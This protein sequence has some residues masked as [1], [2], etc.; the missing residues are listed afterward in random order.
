MNKYRFK[1]TIARIGLTTLA[2]VA[3]LAGPLF[4]WGESNPRALAMGG[5]YTAL[6]FGHEAAGYNPANLGLSRTNS[7]TIDLFS[8]GVS[9][10]NNS[11]SLADYNKYTGAFLTD[12]DKDAI[13]DKIPSEGLKL[14]VLT[15]AAGLNFAVGRLAFNFRGLGASKINLDR[16]PF[17]LLLYGNAVKSDVSLSDTRGE[18]W[19][20]A[21]GA[22]SYGHS[23][24]QWPGGELAIG[25]SFHY[26]YGI[27]HEK[28]T[29]A[30]GGVSTTPGGFIGDGRMIVRS[31][32][33]GSGLAL[34]LG[35][36][37][38][39]AD[40]WVFSASWQNVYSRIK[41]DRDNEEML[42]TFHM[43]PIN[44]DNLADDEIS[45]SLVTSSDTTYDVAPFTSTLPSVIKLGISRS[46]KKLTW[47]LDWEQ[48]VS[49]GAS[50]AVT[51]RIAGGL[52]YFPVGFLPLRAGTA[53]GGD[54]GTIFSTGFG[55]KLGAFRLDTAIA[56]N[57]TLNPG[58]VK[59]ASFALAMGLRF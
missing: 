36:A 33:G 54:R 27:A 13:I 19:A 9:L 22:L 48:G 37:M 20:I 50:Q 8:V 4:A 30:E 28:I 56:S 10:K 2:I 45:D 21:D 23:L 31:S 7:F 14:N 1:I 24:K 26:L 44:Y 17:E 35:T 5:A 12:S 29:Y 53:F 38:V 58:S 51:P 3:L 18:A 11:F 46:Y 32:L 49:S 6:S 39:F 40:K 55:L 57:G 42:L 15:E 52:E 41:W 43:D 25:G 34:D 16:D 47:A 59:G